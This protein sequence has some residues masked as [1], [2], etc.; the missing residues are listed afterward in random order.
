MSLDQQK[1]EE[2]GAL[3]YERFPKSINFLDLVL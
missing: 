1:L 2:L 3:I